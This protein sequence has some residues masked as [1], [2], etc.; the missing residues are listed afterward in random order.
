MKMAFLDDEELL[1]GLSIALP[2]KILSFSP[3]EGQV[4]AALKQHYSEGKAQGQREVN[5]PLLS[6]IIKSGHERHV[7]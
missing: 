7:I 5:S 2:P 4:W 1:G 6:Q 3:E